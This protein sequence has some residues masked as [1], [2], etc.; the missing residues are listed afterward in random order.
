M[1]G[2]YNNRTG[3]LENPFSPRL[4]GRAPEKGMIGREPLKRDPNLTW[5]FA[6]SVKRWFWPPDMAE[7]KLVLY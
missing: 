2:K 1:S 6:G 5:T 7:T 4:A 3:D